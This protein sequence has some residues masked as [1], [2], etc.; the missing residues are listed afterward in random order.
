MQFFE[1]KPESHGYLKVVADG[2]EKTRSGFSC[3][4]NGFTVRP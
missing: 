2:I 3:S 1:E 4:K